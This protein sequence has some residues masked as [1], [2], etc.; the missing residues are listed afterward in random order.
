MSSSGFPEF[1]IDD[2]TMFHN[3]NLS[4]DNSIL[5]EFGW[6]SLNGA[7]PSQPYT[8]VDVWGDLDNYPEFLTPNTAPV[9]LYPTHG[10]SLNE[11]KS[12]YTLMVILRRLTL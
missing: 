11:G 8:G 5:N 12:P 6:N 10:V 9:S 2:L 7:G 3:N 1:N 4:G